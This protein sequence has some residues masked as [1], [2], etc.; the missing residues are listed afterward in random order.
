MWYWHLRSSNKHTL[1]CELTFQAHF[2]STTNKWQNWQKNVYNLLKSVRRHKKTVMSYN[3]ISIQCTYLIW[4]YQSP[5]SGLVRYRI[6]SLCFS[7]KS[8]WHLFYSP[9]PPHYNKRGFAGASLKCT[10]AGHDAHD[11]PQSAQT[12][13]VNI[14]GCFNCHHFIGNI[15]GSIRWMLIVHFILQPPWLW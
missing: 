3:A 7:C 10:T 12:L 8:R 11:G 13:T 1:L 2:P 6:M 4:I 5:S 15:N 14:I 9:E